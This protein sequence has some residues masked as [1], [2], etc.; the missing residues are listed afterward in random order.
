[1]KA[2]NSTQLT[3]EKEKRN[4]CIEKNLFLIFCIKSYNKLFNNINSDFS[5]K[6][7]F[8]NAFDTAVCGKTFR[9][10]FLIYTLAMK[11]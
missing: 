6:I 8:N 1:M 10:L 9:A 5:F 7:M 3:R 11:A 4:V 2:T